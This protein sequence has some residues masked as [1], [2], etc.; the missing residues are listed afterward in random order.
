MPN[1]KNTKRKKIFYATS[2]CGRDYDLDMRCSLE[3]AIHNGSKHTNRSKVE[4]SERRFLKMI[5][6]NPEFTNP[7]DRF[8]TWKITVEYLGE[9]K[10]KR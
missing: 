10:I 4:R 5:Q 2:S 7:K 3:A 1:N 9:T 8:R 6:H